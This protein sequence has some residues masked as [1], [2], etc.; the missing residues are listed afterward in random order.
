[1]ADGELIA[2]GP[3]RAV[4]AGSLAFSTQLNRLL[5]GDVLTLADALRSGALCG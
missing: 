3:P 1:M 4:L 2:D 5:G